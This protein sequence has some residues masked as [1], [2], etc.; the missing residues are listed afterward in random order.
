MQNTYLAF[1]EGCCGGFSHMSCGNGRKAMAYTVRTV[2]LLENV[3]IYFK[4]S[5]ENFKNFPLAAL[6]TPEAPCINNKKKFL[7]SLCVTIFY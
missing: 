4:K 7:R 5:V 2:D 3:Q 6:L 1:S